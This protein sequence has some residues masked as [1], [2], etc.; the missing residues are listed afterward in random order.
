[1]LQTTFFNRKK[2]KTMKDI[3]YL[4][5]AQY[6]RKIGVSRSRV[7]QMMKQG[8]LKTVKIYGTEM[9]DTEEKIIKT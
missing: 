9:I 2:S 7:S 5:P 6:A 4:T 3:K 1:V 8:K